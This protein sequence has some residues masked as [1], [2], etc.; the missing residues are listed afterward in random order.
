MPV[1]MNAEMNTELLSSILSEIQFLRKSTEELRE[2][3]QQLKNQLRL[4]ESS[5]ERKLNKKLKKEILKV[6]D[7]EFL[8]NILKYQDHRT[9]LE[10]FKYYYFDECP[11]KIISERKIKIFT[12]KGWI[13]DYDGY[14]TTEILSCNIY[15]TLLKVNNMDNIEDSEVFLKNQMY[16]NKFLDDKYRRLVYKKIKLYMIDHED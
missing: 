5:T 7:K 14:R 3:N 2:E 9:E 13:D 12:D 10:L 8:L 16:L 15:R 6:D 4:L 1:I 11:I